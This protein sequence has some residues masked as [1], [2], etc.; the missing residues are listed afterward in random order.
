MDR[1]IKSVYSV[2]KHDMIVT[3]NNDY[4]ETIIG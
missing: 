2:S 1:K 4:E 3:A